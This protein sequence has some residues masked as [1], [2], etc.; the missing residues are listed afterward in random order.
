[1]QS[2]DIEELF[3]QAGHF[4]KLLRRAFEDVTGED[5]DIETAIRHYPLVA[6][7]LAAGAGMLGGWTLARRSK[8]Q[9][10]PPKPRLSFDS[11]R[12]IRSR[13]ADLYADD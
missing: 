8:P 12:D 3:S 13:Q 7:G 6:V 1:M 4:L 11:L 10:P 9:L 5:L 2:D